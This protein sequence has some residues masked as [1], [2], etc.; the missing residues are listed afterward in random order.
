MIAF[1]PALTGDQFGLTA[2]LYVGHRDPD[3]MSADRLPASIAPTNSPS[4]NSL[5]RE[6]AVGRSAIRSHHA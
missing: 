4:T 3:V 2:M 1:L 6:S 5:H